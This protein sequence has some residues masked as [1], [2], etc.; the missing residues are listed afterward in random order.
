MW[1]SHP[2]R[3]TALDLRYQLEQQIA[4]K[5]LRDHRNLEGL[6]AIEKDEGEIPMFYVIC[7]S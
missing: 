4:Q 3:F 5:E 2:L 7:V 1:L 6:D